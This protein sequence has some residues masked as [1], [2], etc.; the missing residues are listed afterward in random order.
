[1]N[2]MG[3]YLA[4]A[5]GIIEV[6]ECDKCG[7]HCIVHNKQ[8]LEDKHYYKKNCEQYNDIRMDE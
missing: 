2:K 8:T 4:Y 6:H 3:Y 7:Y 5:N 1:M